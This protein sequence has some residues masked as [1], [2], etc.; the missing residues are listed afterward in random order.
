MSD[1][2]LDKWDLRFL[3]LARFVSAWSKD[4]STKVGAVIADQAHRVC[5]LGYN[6]LPAGVKDLRGRLEDRDIKLQIALHAE[7]NALAFA[8][9][10]RGC[11]IYTWP[12]PPCAHC[13][14][15][16][17]QHGIFRVVAPRATR[18]EWRDSSDLGIEMAIEAGLTVTL[19]ENDI[20]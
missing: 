14:S 8:T 18:P 7:E 3:E 17:I 1:T 5:G 12:L 13:M 6:G 16:I 10:T 15:S 19:F 9:K 11:S 4:P 2:D 20:P